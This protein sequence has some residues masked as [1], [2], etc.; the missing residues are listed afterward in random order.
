MQYWDYY[1]DSFDWPNAQFS[2]PDIHR[3]MHRFAEL[4]FSI[5]EI[6]ALI[7]SGYAIHEGDVVIDRYYGGLLMSADGMTRFRA[8]H[9]VDALK[10]GACRTP[11]VRVSSTAEARRQIDEWRKKSRQPLLFRGQ[12]SSYPLDRKVRNPFFKTETFGEISL[13]PSLWRR[14]RQTKPRHYHEF[15]GLTIFEWSRVLYEQF[16]LEE[17]ERRQMAINAAGGWM[18][19]AQD[20]ADSDDPLLQEFGRTRLD[21]MV[22]FNMAQPVHLNTI[23]QHYGLC[24]PVLDL[25]SDEDVALFF[26]SHKFT[27]GANGSEYEF[28]GNNSGQSVL[29][30]I[31]QNDTEMLPHEHARVLNKMQALRPIRQSC[32][33]C[34]SGAASLNL[35]ALYLIGVI[36]LD[37]DHEGDVRYSTR[38]LFPPKEEDQLLAAMLRKLLHPEHL[39]EFRYSA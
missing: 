8:D 25:T 14:Q 38:D 22:G 36:Q 21:L 39:T 3:T 5:S 15:G 4:G 30:V 7:E 37:F 16:D 34:T 1:D 13:L 2:I 24:S 18:H 12:T 11:V 10:S 31:R 26:A 27:T 23:L 28:I 9:F 19:S 33:I 32:V 20:M 35:A 6:E 29:Y 17:I